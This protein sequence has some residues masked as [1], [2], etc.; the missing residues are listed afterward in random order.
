M[1]WGMDDMLTDAKHNFD[2][3]IFKNKVYIWGA[4]YYADFIYPEIDNEQCIVVGVVDSDTEKQGTEWKHGLHISPPE[5]LSQAAFDYVFISPKNY[6]GIEKQCSDMGIPKEKIVT[7]WRD[8]DAAG[9]FRNRADR[10]LEAEKRCDRYRNRYLNAP[11]EWGL[12]GEPA[13]RIRSAED[14]LNRI[15]AEGCSLCTYGDGE[16]EIMLHRDR[17]WFQKEDNALAGRLRE[18]I[19]SKR[20]NVIVA[21]ADNFGTLEKYKEK[22]ADDIREYMVPNRQ[23]ICALLDKDCV[24]Y[25]AYVSRPY[26]IYRDKEH[27]K[28]IFGLF[29]KIWQ[30]RDVLLV[31]GRKSRIGVG[32][33]LFWEAKGVSRIECPEKNAWNIYEDIL[34]TVKE[35]AGKDTLVCISLGPTATVLAY[36]LALAGYQ[37][38]DIGQL[39]NEYEWYIRGVDQRIAIPGKMV[40]EVEK[41][42]CANDM[43][44]RNA[45]WEDEYRKQIV[46]EAGV[47]NMKRNKERTENG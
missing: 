29:K 43:T 40:A 22:M 11:F 4:G 8:K 17:A 18:I 39:D 26:I 1:I 45:D 44:G 3:E 14:L 41:G 16:F 35:K 5:L 33:D 19:V 38:L 21:L 6:T 32:N 20:D 47:W 12:A 24:Y 2:K 7:Y 31:E 28:T 23:E 10:V 13:V 36:D 30:G 37:A 27:A 25:D 34:R 15:I 9:V 42:R 46:A